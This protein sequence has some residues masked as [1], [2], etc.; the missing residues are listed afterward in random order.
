MGLRLAQRFNGEIVSVDSRLFYRGMDI[1][2][3]KPTPAERALVPHHLIDLCQPDETLGLGEFMGL[4]Y[5]AI[6]DIL[7]RGRLPV[8]VGGTGQYVMA[9]V[10]G[11]N[12]PEVTPRPA[13]RHELEKLPQDKSARWLAA[14]DP[15]TAERTDLRNPRRVIRALEVIL[16]TGERLS[17][18]QTKSPPPYKFHMVGLARDRADLYGRIDARVDAMMA[19]GLLTEVEALQA[20]GYSRHNPSMTGL[21]YRQLL[22]HLEGQVTLEEA[23]AQIKFDTHRFARRQ[24]AWFRAGDPRIE[25]FDASQSTDYAADIEAHVGQWLGSGAERP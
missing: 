4:A 8:L 21:G 16:S 18:L 12:V 19:A 17:S 23:M 9:V 20:A 22:D 5:H 10:E 6:D 15:Q 25:W 11:W 13:L 7:A 3:A 2:T 14:L 24:G 1:G